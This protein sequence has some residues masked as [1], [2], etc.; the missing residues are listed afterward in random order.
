MDPDGDIGY[1][2]EVDVE[3]PDG[4]HNLHN[5]LPFMPERMKLKGGEKL[6][7]TLKDKKNY[8][9]HYRNLQQAISNGLKVKKIHRTLKFNQS[10]WMASYINLNN[11]R[12]KEA[13]SK[14]KKDLCKLMNNAVFGKTIENIMKRRSIRFC[15]SWENQGKKV[16]AGNLIAS[17]RIKR[18][19][20]FDHDFIACELKQMTLKFDKPIQVGFTVLELAKLK[21]YD[22]HYN[23]ML[24]QFNQAQI[25]YTDTDSFIYKIDTDDVYEDLKN[26]VN[27]PESNVFDTSDYPCD[28]PFGF[29][30]RNKKLLGA[31]KDECC[32]KIMQEFIGLRSKCY[33]F[34]CLDEEPQNKSKGV[35]RN[36][37][38]KLTM[39]EYSQ[40]L[41]DRNLKILKQQYIFRSDLH[42]VYTMN[43]NKVAL[44]SNDDK[45][46]ILPDGISTL[47]IGHYL[48][49]HMEI[50]N[51]LEEHQTSE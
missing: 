40:S 44:N 32:G 29:Q 11:Q 22:F 6:C 35:K 5:D 12:R 47:A 10:N 8:T 15:K 45:R 18:I 50:L 9:I 36:V 33:S 27:D 1:I 26:I 23:F 24:Q 28:N 43:I 25:C 51:D 38:A 39:E 21:M 48:I 3:Y 4:L 42:R 13:T 49:N 37:V 17:G 19:T 14:S 34:K 7:T 2:I 41:E 30:L 16:G 31:M 20:E 46:F